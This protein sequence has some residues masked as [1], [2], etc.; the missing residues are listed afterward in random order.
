MPLDEEAALF[1][2]EDDR[3]DGYDIEGEDGYDVEGEDEYDVEGEDR[4]FVGREDGYEYYD[5]EYYG[6]DGYYDEEYYAE[7]AEYEY[8]NDEIQEEQPLPEERPTDS[9]WKCAVC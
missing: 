2:G 4:D 9:G 1:F 7:Y 5:D 3:D 8:D 6:S